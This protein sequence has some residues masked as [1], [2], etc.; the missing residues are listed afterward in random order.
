MARSARS[1]DVVVV[2]A[3]PSDGPAGASSGAIATAVPWESSNSQSTS[4]I[5][6]AAT[7]GDIGAVD[8]GSGVGGE[9]G[10]V[11]DGGVVTTAARLVLGS[12]GTAAQ[13]ATSD[14]RIA[15]LH[16]RKVA[17][18]WPLRLWQVGKLLKISTKLKG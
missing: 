4:S 9:A 13:A 18:P 1:C 6:G 17:P 5:T 2:T 12:S 14:A 11:R 10:I 3:R 8:Q 7:L 15:A 16:P